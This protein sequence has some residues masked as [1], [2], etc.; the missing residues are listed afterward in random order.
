MEQWSKNWK[1]K[2]SGSPLSSPLVEFTLQLEAPRTQLGISIPQRIQIQLLLARAKPGTTTN[3]V[4]MLTCKLSLN[5]AQ[6]SR[7]GT[8]T[9]SGSTKMLW[10]TKL[11]TIASLLIANLRTMLILTI[12][13][14][15]RMVSSCSLGRT[16]AT[17]EFGTS[18]LGRRSRT[19]RESPSAWRW[20][21][22]SKVPLRQTTTLWLLWA[23]AK[24]WMSTRLL[25]W[26]PLTKLNHWFYSL[27]S[28]LAL[29]NGLQTV[30][31]WPSEHGKKL[32]SWLSRKNSKSQRFKSHHGI[33]LALQSPIQ[34]GL[35]TI[36]SLGDG[37]KRWK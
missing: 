15:P 2:I 37:T 33:K 21:Q 11:P 12:S 28:N 31:S 29:S 9:L 3:G 17:T 19:S 26:W 36:P 6:T 20:V 34:N 25:I 13:S 10:S 35:I 32:L 30:S 24:T 23:R 27:M 8:S 1:I 14:S 4:N 22:T 18:L 7:T 16:T 5:G